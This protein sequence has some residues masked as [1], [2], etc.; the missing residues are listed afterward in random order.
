MKF[1]PDFLADMGVVAEAMRDQ[2]RSWN[3]ISKRLG[4][5]YETTRRLLRGPVALWPPVTTR[6]W[7]DGTAAVWV[8]LVSL[9]G[10]T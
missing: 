7:G 8:E 9:E 4:L 3:A 10:R 2:G 5:S 6:V 1:T